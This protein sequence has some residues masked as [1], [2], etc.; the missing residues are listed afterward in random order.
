M[1]ISK[2]PLVFLSASFRHFVM[3]TG[4]MSSVLEDRKW[5][6]SENSVIPFFMVYDRQFMS[7]CRITIARMTPAVNVV[8]AMDNVAWCAHI[9]RKG[10]RA[11]G[12]SSASCRIYAIAMRSR[13]KALPV[14]ERLTVPTGSTFGQHTT[15]QSAGWSG[16]PGIAYSAGCVPPAQS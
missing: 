4:T 11:A 9:S 2:L 7:I 1:K 6:T 5:G 10:W 3:Q 13:L 12:F 8:A 16:P 15:L 14:A